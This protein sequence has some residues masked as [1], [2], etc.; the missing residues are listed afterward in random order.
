[1]EHIS[2]LLEEFV[3]RYNFGTVYK[4]QNFPFYKSD[5]SHVIFNMLSPA[6]AINI[7]KASS[8]NGNNSIGF[9]EQTP[10]IPLISYNLNSPLIFITFSTRYIYMPTIFVKSI[11]E[12][13]KSLSFAYNASNKHRLPI[14]IIISKELKVNLTPNK[15]Y[16]ESVEFIKSTPNESKRP[17]ITTLIDSLKNI[18]EDFERYFN[19]KDESQ[20]ELLSLNDNRGSFLNYLI[21][22]IQTPYKETLEGIE[23]IAILEDEEEFIKTLCCQ[24]DINVQLN[25]TNLPESVKT[26]DILCP[27]CPFLVLFKK[28]KLQCDNIYTNIKCNTI[29]RI[30]QVK[31]GNLTDFIGLTLEQKVHKDYYVGNLSEFEATYTNNNVIYLNNF[32]AEEEKMFF[33]KIKYNKSIKIFD[34]SCNNVPKSK[35]SKVNL[36]KCKCIKEHKDP[37]CIQETLCP[38]IFINGET[39]QINDKYCVDCKVCKIVCPYRAIK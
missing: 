20:I 9:F 32:K 17:S 30:F 15:L 10:D 11:E 29:K 25:T 34:Y 35:P 21:P 23:A 2:K 38:A 13:T 6:E 28:E 8:A 39:V 14:N 26:M 1:M 12:L 18:N 7:L 3:D 36:R 24:F 19:H 27:G 5:N 31:E 22:M 33:N 16:I 4:E 37:C